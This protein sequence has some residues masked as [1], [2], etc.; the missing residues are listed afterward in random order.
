MVND[1]QDKTLNQVV[2]PYAGAPTYEGDTV[3]TTTQPQQLKPHLHEGALKGGGNGNL[4]SCCCLLCFFTA[5]VSFP[6]WL[7]YCCLDATT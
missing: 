6:L 7:V 1:Q 5:G 4:H 2:P 3:I